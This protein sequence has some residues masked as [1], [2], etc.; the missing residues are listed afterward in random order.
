MIPQTGREMNV[1]PQF[2]GKVDEL[3]KADFGIEQPAVCISTQNAYDFAAIPD[4]TIDYVFT[5]PP[6]GGTIQY[7][8]LSVV[9]E[10]WQGFDPNWRKDEITI[11]A[12]RDKT[13]DDWA[14]LI[15]KSMAECYRVLKPGRWLSLCY[16]DTSE[17]TWALVQDIM[18]EVGF[19]VD[20]TESALFID[21]GQK[22]TISLQRTKQR[23]VTWCST[24][25]SQR[26]VTGFQRDCSSR[27]MWMCLPSRT[28]TRGDSRCPHCDPDHRRTASMMN[29]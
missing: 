13:E 27:P 14:G 6:Y 7:G 5:D 19:I 17:G 24:S 2:E 23:S 9:W 3:L 8:E 22:R 4:E 1:W 26:R 28:W 29:W 15:R 20:K 25:T 10:A 11:A 21:T 18:A 16:H 12:V